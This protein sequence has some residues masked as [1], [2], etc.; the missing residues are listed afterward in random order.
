MWALKWIW[1]CF[2][3]ISLV[4]CAY[5]AKIADMTFLCIDRPLSSN[6][7]RWCR[8]GSHSFPSSAVKKV[9]EQISGENRREKLF[10]AI[11]VLH[12]YFSYD[13]WLLSRA[14]NR[15]ADE[16]F[17]S[18]KLGCCSDYALALVTLLRF[19]DVP[20]RFLLTVNLDWVAAYR[21]NNLIIPRGHVFVEVFL[22]NSW[23][24]VD[25]V[26]QTLYE[27]YNLNNKNY[28]HKEYFLARLHDF[29]DAGFC[30]LKDIALFYRAFANGFFSLD[31]QVP[32]YHSIK[33]A[34]K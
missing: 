11:A 20:S 21:Q 33:L 28:P 1:I 32:Q 15:T 26:Y 4:G 23:F 2:I 31:N 24:L 9:A 3:S 18:S 25:P 8:P 10:Q 29:A 14:F 7:L 27:G 19:L 17:K 34:I 16:L 13:S 22:E 12:S 30:S 5:Q 6:T